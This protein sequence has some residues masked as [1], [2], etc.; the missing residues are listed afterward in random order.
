MNFKSILVIAISSSLI[1]SSCN[2]KE[3]KKNETEQLAPLVNLS[4]VKKKTFIHEIRVQGNIETDQDVLLTAEMGG[5]I[6][7]IKVKEG[8]TVHKGQVIA[9]IDAAILSSSVQE[10]ETQLEYAEYVLNKQKELQKRGVG[11]EFDLETAQNQVNALKAKKNSLNTQRGKATIKAPFSGVI[12]DVFAKKGQM[13]GAQTPIVRLVNNS[14][15]NLIASLSEK[16]IKS[17]DIGTKMRVSFPNYS[18]TTIELAITSI[19]NYINPT[20]RTF[21]VRSTIKN[22]TFLIPN[23]LAEVAITDMIVENGLVIPTKSILKDQENK[24][25]VFVAE[26]KGEN[27]TVKK[28]TVEIVQKYNGETLIKN[29]LKEGQLVVTEGARGIFEGDIVR[30]K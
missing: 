12:D 19:G 16:H 3:D 27:Y 22:N 5:I 6:T 30:S 2:Q 9:T 8:Q 25:Y 26:K 4:P 24:D 21:H 7:S 18:D 17:V 14:T 13:A 20:N 1:L 15:V 11:S 29:G 28:A 23:M 10:I